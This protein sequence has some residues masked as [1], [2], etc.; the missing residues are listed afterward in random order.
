M[1]PVCHF[2]NT[3]KNKMYAQNYMHF[4]FEWKQRSV[5]WGTDI[6][7]EWWWRDASWWGQSTLVN[8]WD[9]FSWNIQ[10]LVSLGYALV[11]I[12]SVHWRS[13]KLCVTLWSSLNEIHENLVGYEIQEHMYWWWNFHTHCI[14]IIDSDNKCGW[15]TSKLVAFSFLKFN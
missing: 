10:F 6:W 5:C 1:I 15:K 2:C 8:S 13:C 7:Y 11:S 9:Q 14:C 3:C 12:V 4:I